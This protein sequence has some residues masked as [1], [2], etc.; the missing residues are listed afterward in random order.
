MSYFDWALNEQ[1]FQYQECALLNPF[2]NAGKAVM[3]I[4][5]SL[6]VKKFCPAANAMNFNSLKKAPA[7]KAPRK[8]CR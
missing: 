7:L 2:R 6:G 1:C 5:Y 4:E 3:N 8:A